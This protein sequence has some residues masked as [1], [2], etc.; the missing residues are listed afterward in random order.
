[1]LIIKLDKMSKEESD[2]MRFSKK[3]IENYDYR[4]GMKKFVNDSGIMDLIKEK[5]SLIFDFNARWSVLHTNYGNRRGK[6]VKNGNF[7]EQYNGI[8]VEN[9]IGYYL[10]SIGA[11]D[12]DVD[13]FGF[14]G[15]YDFEIGDALVDVKTVSRNVKMN[16]DYSHNLF[17][18]QVDGARYK[19][20]YYIL[21]S[22]NQRSREIAITSIIPRDIVHGISH[23][24]DIGDNLVNNAKT[25]GVKQKFY[26]I[27]DKDIPDE[28]RVYSFGDIL[29]IIGLDR[30]DYPESVERFYNDLSKDIV[31][32]KYDSIKY[33][34]SDYEKKY[35]K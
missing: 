9:V 8:L 7:I 6:N 29:D 17:S 30:M 11:L 19:S 32:V 2:L 15:G 35:N 13:S 4:G 33:K 1:M 5:P 22:Y 10:K 25:I 26:E 24:R 23:V 21:S 27:I 12:S 14:D 18:S 16:K 34:G 3:D 28:Y 20:D 31:K